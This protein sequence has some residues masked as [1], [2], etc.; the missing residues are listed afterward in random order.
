[1][2]RQQPQALPGEEF[3]SRA[4]PASGL[5]TWEDGRFTEHKNTSAGAIGTSS[6]RPHLT[7]AQAAIQEIT[8]RQS[9]WTPSES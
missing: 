8:D 9:G 2:D 6:N 4:P 3:A 1:V 7:E 5:V